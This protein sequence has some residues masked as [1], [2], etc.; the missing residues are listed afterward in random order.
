M[1]LLNCEKVRGA[2]EY[3]GIE[4]FGVATLLWDS[5]GTTNAMRAEHNRRSRGI[6]AEVIPKVESW[7]S[8][9]LEFGTAVM[10][11]PSYQVMS[12]LIPTTLATACSLL[13]LYVYFWKG[14]FQNDSGDH[15]TR[16]SAY[17]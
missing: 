1:A 14:E 12:C 3:P 13:I 5:A 4:V 2:Y 11:V 8:V 17:G 9:F 6:S 16:F 15:I 10:T 7:I